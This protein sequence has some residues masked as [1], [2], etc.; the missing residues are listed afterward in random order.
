MLD[1]N[2]KVCLDPKCA[3]ILLALTNPLYDN[4]SERERIAWCD[5][6]NAYDNYL[7]HEEYLHNKLNTINE[8]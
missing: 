8:H 1:Q 7:D 4:L 3:Q 5:L 2:S 6:R